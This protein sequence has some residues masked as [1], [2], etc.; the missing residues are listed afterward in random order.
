[1]YSPYDIQIVAKMSP[2]INISLTFAV[3]CWNAAD[4]ARIS[5]VLLALE[6]SLTFNCAFV[7]C[8]RKKLL[9]YWIDLLRLDGISSWCTYFSK[10]MINLKNNNK[11]NE[12]RI[13]ETV[14]FLFQ[15]Y[16]FVLL[17][18]DS[19]LFGWD[20]FVRL[21]LLLYVIFFFCI[22]LSQISQIYSL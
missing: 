13:N 8:W 11:N 5:L 21:I 2:I 19:F 12:L 18:N 17:C 4:V 9:I 3:L 16:S 14:T 22:H 10:K 20:C 7:I 1:M 6:K 15:L